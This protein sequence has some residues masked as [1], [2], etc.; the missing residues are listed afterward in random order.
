MKRLKVKIP[1]KVNEV[2]VL[3]QVDDF[4]GKLA[5]AVVDVIEKEV[6]KHNSKKEEK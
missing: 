1:T 3:K 4:L 6:K 5:T 2:K